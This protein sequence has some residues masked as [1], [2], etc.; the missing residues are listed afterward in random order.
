MCSSLGVNYFYHYFTTEE[1]AQICQQF[2]SAWSP[3]KQVMWSGIPY[4]VAQE[5]ADRHQMQTLTAAMGPLM[6][7][8]DPRCLRSRL[9]SKKWSKYI[10]GASALFAYHV[11]QDQGS[12]TVLTPPPPERFHPSGETNYQAVEEPIL[13]GRLEARSVSRIELVHP[14]VTGAEDA[15]YQFWPVDEPHEWNTQFGR[16]APRYREWRRVR[17][18]HWKL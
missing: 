14:T 17:K 16:V 12:V 7:H 11:A 6:K 4:A 18:K 13:K 8:D 3:N 2:H 9:D 5:W 15:H 1:L 10:Q